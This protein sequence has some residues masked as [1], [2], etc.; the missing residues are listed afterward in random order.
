[1][2][3]QEELDRINKYEAELVYDF[4]IDGVY[5]GRTT[6]DSLDKEEFLDELGIDEAYRCHFSEYELPYM[7][8]DFL[9]GSTSSLVDLSEYTDNRLKQLRVDRI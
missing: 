4:W 7:L 9:D 2:F 5:K 3:S 8:R 1:M 6:L